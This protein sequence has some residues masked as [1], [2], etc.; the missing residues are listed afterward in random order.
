M[1]LWIVM[2]AMVALVL[3]GCA[4]K[5]EEMAQYHQS[6]VSTNAAMLASIKEQAKDN[7][8]AR[9]AQ[10]IHFSKAMTEASRTADPTDNVVIAFA[11]GY[12]SGQELTVV[13]PE[14][15]YPKAPV[16]DVD[17]VRAWTPIASMAVP[18]I[19]PLINSWAY[20]YGSSGTKVTQQFAVSDQGQLNIDSGNSGSQKSPGS[21]FMGDYGTG[22]VTNQQ[23]D[24]GEGSFAGVPAEEEEG[25]EGEVNPLSADGTD[26]EAMA[27]CVATAPGGYT[28]I[29]TPLAASGLSCGSTYGF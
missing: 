20:D 28:A 16:T 6:L 21:Y 10:M 22:A 14:L 18:L 23:D 17:R 9:M 25:A 8:A 1:R 7:K 27:E 4:A 24:Y 3:G 29:G 2:A 12:Q 11:W 5:P 26:Q 19:Y 13:T 15:K